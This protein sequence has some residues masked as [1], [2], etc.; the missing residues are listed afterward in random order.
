MILRTSSSN[1]RTRGRLLGLWCAALSLS[2]SACG[3]A[4]GGGAAS[5]TNS[6]IGAPAPNFAAEP[7]GGD[8]PRSPKEARGKVVILDFWGTFCEPCKKSF[9]KYQEIVDQFPGEV[10]V[11]AVSVDEPGNVKKDQLQQFALENHAKFAI[12]WDKDHSVADKYGLKSLTM[13]SSFILDK[14]G[15][16]RHL[17]AGFKDGDEAKVTEEVKAL[18]AG[19]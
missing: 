10:T 16:V 2:A 6:L 19:E 17:H 12:V 3:G 1:T 7:V 9:P 8:G 11:L 5:A 13:P 14:K 15:V 18:V 4:S